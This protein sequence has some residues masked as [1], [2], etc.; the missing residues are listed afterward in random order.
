MTD[1]TKKGLQKDYKLSDPE[2]IEA[3]L[4]LIPLFALLMLKYVFPG[5][6]IIQKYFSGLSQFSMVILLMAIVWIRSKK[7][8]KTEND[9]TKS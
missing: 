2:I 8:Y 5:N 3:I 1:G 9:K 7:T 4:W 6:Q